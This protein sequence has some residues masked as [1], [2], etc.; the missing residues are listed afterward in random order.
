MLRTDRH[1]LPSVTQFRE[2]N[3]ENGSWVCG[4]RAATADEKATSK[5]LAMT[6]NKVQ[7]TEVDCPA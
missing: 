4:A 6:E 3:A 5:Q 7:G 2:Q 1:D